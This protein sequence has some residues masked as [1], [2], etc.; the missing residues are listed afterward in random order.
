M[1][2]LQEHDSKTVMIT[3]PHDGVGT[4]FLISVLGCNIARFSTM[5]VLLVDL[6]MRRPQLNRSFGLDI[7]KGFSAVASG[8][9]PWREAV[10][11]TNL[12]GLRIMP[13]GRIDMDFSPLVNRSFLA[14]LIHEMQGDF[15]LLFFDT[16]PLLVQNRGNVDPVLLSLICD[17]V[18]I[19]VQDKKTT[20]S[21]LFQAVD[22]IPEGNKKVVGIVYNHIF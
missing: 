12:P 17:A 2:A 14:D 3:G 10:M 4:T 7:G 22:A 20:R 9:L 15:D 6:N 16:S 5:R 13:A 19:M 18:V 8:L 21:D 1:G 11:D